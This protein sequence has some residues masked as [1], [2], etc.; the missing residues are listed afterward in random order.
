MRK[1]YLILAT[2]FA[3]FI[4]I[5]PA[6]EKEGNETNISQAGRHSHNAGLNCMN[7]HHSG[8]EGEG[9]FVVAGTA[10]DSTIT[11]TYPNTVLKL[12]TAPHGGGTLKATLYGDASGSFYTTENVDFSSGLYPAVTGTSGQTQYMTESISTGACNSCHGISQAHIW[13]Q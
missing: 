12:Y 7:C 6:C 8:G 4:I 5:L 10:Y 9:W 13:A 3:A 2:L 11:H 1:S